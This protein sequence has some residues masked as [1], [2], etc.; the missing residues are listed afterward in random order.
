MKTLSTQ[1]YWHI[2]H[3]SKDF[4][5]A[6][7]F[8]AMFQLQLFLQ[9]GA[10]PEIMRYLYGVCFYIP[11]PHLTH[12][13][14]KHCYKTENSKPRCFPSTLNSEDRNPRDPTPL[15][16]PSKTSTFWSWN[17]HTRSRTKLWTKNGHSFPHLK[18]K[19][20]VSG[21]GIFFP[22]GPQLF[23]STTNLR[24]RKLLGVLL[25]V[26]FHTKWQRKQDRLGITPLEYAKSFS[27]PSGTQRDKTTV[28]KKQPQQEETRFWEENTKLC[29]KI[30]PRHGATWT[31]IYCK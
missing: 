10:W 6:L 5:K 7:C 2:L 31:R 8:V 28:R 26:T 23:T 3:V 1:N 18:Q 17:F 30:K 15:K 21:T 4:E 16:I 20:K 14:A 27:K 25:Y 24:Q 12:L 13:K 22:S 9:V 19:R 29:L 11:R